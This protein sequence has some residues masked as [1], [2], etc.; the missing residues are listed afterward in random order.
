MEQGNEQ[1]KHNEEEKGYDA[2]QKINLVDFQKDPKAK[3]FKCEQCPKAYGQKY[4][5]R[6]HVEAA[7]DKI[8][9]FKCEEC[10]Y[11]SARKGPFSYD[12]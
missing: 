1:R 12:V 6:A 11:A 8:K 7:H 10:D 2:N 5:L 9:R 4:Q 3:A